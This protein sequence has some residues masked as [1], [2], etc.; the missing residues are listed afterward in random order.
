MGAPFQGGGTSSPAASDTVAGVVELA[1]TAET[2]TGTDT[3]RAVTPD[4][5][6][7]CNRL[8]NGGMSITPVAVTGDHTVAATDL[9]VIIE[10]ASGTCD[11]T[12][13]AASGSGR[14]LYI[15]RDVG[16][17]STVCTIVCDGTDTIDALNDYVMPEAATGPSLVLC[18]YKS[19]E[20]V[21]L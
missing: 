5:L 15:K 3:A 20:W 17:L 8:F 6:A 4:A 1:T 21:I 2:T 11:V 16:D 10:C 14:T 13:P 7:D 18:D 9:V 19:G 12:L